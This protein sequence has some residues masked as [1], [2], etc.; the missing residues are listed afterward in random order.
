MDMK[1]MYYMHTHYKPKVNPKLSFC[2]ADC[3]NIQSIKCVSIFPLVLALI[4]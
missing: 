2:M 3:F 1:I 4:H